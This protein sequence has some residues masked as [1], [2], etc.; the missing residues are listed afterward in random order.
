MSNKWFSLLSEPPH[1]IEEPHD[2]SVH[3]GDTIKLK[4]RATG[5]PEPDIVWMKNSNKLSLHDSQYHLMSDGSLQ[6]Q[7]AD[8]NT[9]GQYEC[10]AKNILGETKSRPV[11]AVMVDEETKKPEIILPPY[12]VSISATH[13]PIVM[14][15]VATGKDIKRT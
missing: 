12:D 10:M 13:Q 9:M 4:C 3:L 11:R 2:I 14:H 7:N 5:N 8:A 6:I 15:C 1:L